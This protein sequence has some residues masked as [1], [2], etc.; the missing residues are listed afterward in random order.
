MKKINTVDDAFVTKLQ[1]LYDVERELEKALPKMAKKVKDP[2]LKAGLSDHL[3]ET[4]NHT[5]RLESIFE[6]LSV[7]PKK[8]K[9]EGIRG[10]VEDASWVMKQNYSEALMDSMIAAAGRYAEHYEIGG[11]MGAVE[12]SIFLGQNEITALLLETLE[13]EKASDQ[14]LALALRSNLKLV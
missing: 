5:A 7:K 3:K 12:L 1:A 11:Y 10:I 6:L 14:K 13:E 2:T 8:L 9:S 4:K